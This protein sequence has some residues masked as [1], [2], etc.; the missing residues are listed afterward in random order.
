MCSVTTNLEEDITSTSFEAA[1]N[2][3]EKILEQMNSGAISLDESLKLYE[4]ADKLIA[5]CSKR[6]NEAERR[7]EVLVK[8]RNGELAF[9]TDEKPIT[10]EYKM[11]TAAK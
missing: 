7:I 8:N 9:T 11:A 10:Q 5:I 3:L 6:L 2:R 4:E 1:F